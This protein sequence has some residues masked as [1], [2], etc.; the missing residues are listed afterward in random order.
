MQRNTSQRLIVRA[1]NNCSRILPSATM[2]DELSFDALL[3]GAKKQTRLSDFGDETFFNPLKKLISSINQNSDFHP[4][5]S[6]YI[7]KFLTGLLAHRLKLVDYSISHPAILN[8]KITRP[9]IILG[10]PRTGTSLLFNLLAQDPT[11]RFIANWEASVSQVPPNGDYF[12]QSDPRR[13]SGKYLLK[14]QK[15]LMPDIDKLHAFLLDGP[16]ECT[17]I[18]LQS[19]TT[20]AFAGMFNV[21]SYSSWLDQAD[22]EPTYLHHKR[23]LQALQWKYP[24]ERWLL[25]SPDHIA[26][27]NAILKVYPDACIV[28]THRDPTKS[29]ASWASLALHFRS[30]Y[31]R[32]VDTKE[33]GQQVLKQLAQDVERF[34]VEEKHHDSKF[35]YNITYENLVKNPINAVQGIY[36]YFNLPLSKQTEKQMHV[37]MDKGSKHHPGAHKYSPEDF[38]LTA[39]GIRSQFENYLDIFKV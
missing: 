39:R 24:A 35:F 3:H 20:Q 10:L 7:N 14:F 25:K 11:H 6:F 15:Y 21:P 31:Y 4:F 38:G 16:E 33:L 8:E 23:V 32:H 34:I 13:K 17:P 36:E 37:F 28:H 9:I 27:I 1:W 12:F 18:L 19:F 26:S 5:G 2:Q 29:V 30:I 22:H